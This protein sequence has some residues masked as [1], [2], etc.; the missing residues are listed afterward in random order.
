MR[1]SANGVGSWDEAASLGTDTPEAKAPV[2]V[3]VAATRENAA[4][5][6]RSTPRPAAASAEPE[7]SCSRT[8]RDRQ[9]SCRNFEEDR[10]GGPEWYYSHRATTS[11]AHFVQAVEGAR[12]DSGRLHRADLV[13]NETMTGMANRLDRFAVCFRG[14]GR[15]LPDE[16]EIMEQAAKFK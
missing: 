2:A 6:G 8:T 14:P 5:A 7:P 16:P 15:K 13:W 12:R 4:A 3:P 1:C 10:V 9:A 11:R